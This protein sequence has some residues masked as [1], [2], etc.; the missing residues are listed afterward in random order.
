MYPVPS[1]SALGQSKNISWTACPL[2]LKLLHSFDM[3]RSTSLNDM[4]S[5]PKRPEPLRMKLHLCLGTIP[6]RHIT[7]MGMH[8]QEF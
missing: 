7:D 3:L 6:Q 4:L 1:F 5:H 8:R 2:N